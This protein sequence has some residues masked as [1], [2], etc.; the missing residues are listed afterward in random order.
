MA[1]RR[2]SGERRGLS[3]RSSWARRAL[4]TVGCTAGGLLALGLAA[5]PASAHGGHGRPP[6]VSAV[7]ATPPPPGDVLVNLPAA[8]SPVTA[9][10]VEPAGPPAV[11][12]AP[13]VEP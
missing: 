9:A 10:V 11:V 7:V 6:T 8:A 2:E 12:P 13:V 1:V 4:V 5:Q 3:R